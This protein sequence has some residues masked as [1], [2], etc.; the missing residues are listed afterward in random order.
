MDHERDTPTT[1][2]RHAGGFIRPGL[3]VRLALPG[4]TGG[5]AAG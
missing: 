1:G 5:G 2:A 3:A 4:L